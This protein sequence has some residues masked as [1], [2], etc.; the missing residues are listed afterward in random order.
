MKTPLPILSLLG[1]TSVASLAATIPITTPA[2]SGPESVLTEAVLSLVLT[3]NFVSEF[4]DVAAIQVTVG[5]DSPFPYALNILIFNSDPTELWMPA[6]VTLPAGAD[7]VVFAVDTINDG[8]LDGSQDVTIAVDADGFL[9]SDAIV[10]VLDDDTPTCRTIG[11]RLFGTISTESY[12]V[13]GNLTVEVGRTLTILP[14]TT[15]QFQSGKWLTN[16]GTILAD[17]DARSKIVFTSAAAHPTNG[18]WQGITVTSSGAPQTILNHVEIAYAQNG[19]VVQPSGDQANLVLSHSDIHDCSSDGVQ[20]FADRG[21]I[22]EATAVQIATNRVFR[23]QRDGISVTAFI[24][25]CNKSRNSTKVVGNEVFDNLSYGVNLNAGA[26]EGMGCR[27]YRRSIIDG[28]IESNFI[29]GNQY[30][31][32][33]FSD[34]GFAKTI[35]KLSVTIQ[36]NL[37]VNNTLGGIWLDAEAGGELMTKFINN[38]VVRN[39]GAGILHTVNVDSGFTIQN[40]L[41]VENRQGICATAA[42]TPASAAAVVAFN[43]VWANGPDNWIN[44]PAEYGAPVTT[45]ANG[46]PADATMNISAN[47]LFVAAE[48]FRLRP[49]SP[50]VEAGTGNLAPTVDF[51]GQNRHGVPDLGC[52]ELGVFLEPL[53]PSTNGG[54]QMLLTGVPGTTYSIEASTDLQGWVAKTNLTLTN[55]TMRVTVPASPRDQ[56]TFIAPA[57]SE[58]LSPAR[59]SGRRVVVENSVCASPPA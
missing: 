38:T 2:D 4:A 7:S 48:D 52:D 56:R 34:K 41:V 18:D 44:Y 55:R 25:A 57:F 47:P 51:E 20:V 12:L 11:G 46:T 1:A 10:T 50:A 16:A 40:N 36:N 21:I 39:G 49:A 53:A 59:V 42:L 27:D 17:A 23:N 8:D 54:L 13:T 35:S 45:N 5:I 28:V 33:G 58:S 6:S 24:Y 31:I 9:P 30:G 26:S 3:T 14:A 37:I 19:L 29:H 15:L 43:D 22:I 32:Y